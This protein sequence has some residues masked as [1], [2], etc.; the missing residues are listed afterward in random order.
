VGKT[1]ATTDAV[2]ALNAALMGDG[3][4]IHVAKGV[5]LARPIH[6]VHVTDLAVPGAVFTR[7][8]MV[9]EEGAT[10]SLIE[11][12]E[13]AGAAAYQAN[14]VLELVVADKA[15]VERVKVTTE[16]EGALH[17]GSLMAQV[18]AEASLDTFNFTTGGAVVRNQ[19]LVTLA[20]EGTSIRLGGTTLLAGRQHGDTTLVVDH[21]APHCE[22]RESF[23]T[24]LDGEARD[25]FQGRISVK[26]A[27]QKTDGRMMTRA[28]L[29]SETAEADAKPELEIFADDVQ[30]GH[31]CT[32]GSL[33]D[34]LKFYLMARGIPAKEA[35]ALLIEAFVGEV[36]DPV[37][38][39]KVR[40]ALMGALRSWLLARG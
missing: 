14:D 40:E 23:R 27:A 30:C 34:E 16:G 1:V 21:T 13:S 5:A 38:N 39:E 24:V 6:M 2:I 28:L 29:L 18:G 11:T 36:V 35:E 7:S 8:L 3:V 19:M 9:V 17:V 31:G 33:D 20:G 37:A 25:V 26:Q 32:T 15:K 4:V 10:A 12:F 22:S